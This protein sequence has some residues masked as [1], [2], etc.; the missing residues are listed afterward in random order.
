MEN[1]L[2]WWIWRR[3]P[4]DQDFIADVIA[5]LVHELSPDYASLC[6]P[7]QLLTKEY[8]NKHF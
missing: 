3:R 1:L 5:L 7:Y 2:K 4:G 6:G 8:L